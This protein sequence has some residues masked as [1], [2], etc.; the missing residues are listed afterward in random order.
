MEQRDNIVDY[1]EEFHIEEFRSS[2]E[3]RVAMAQW[4]SIGMEVNNNNNNDNNIDDDDDS[5]ENT[6]KYFDQSSFAID[7]YF[8]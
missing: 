7:G 8:L 4:R 6:R 1:D 2:A 3:L 5:D